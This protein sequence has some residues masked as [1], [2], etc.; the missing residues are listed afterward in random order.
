MDAALLA[1]SLKHANATEVSVS[2][3]SA[4]GAAATL[5]AFDLTRGDA[6]ATAQ[7]KLRLRQL[8]TF[9]SPRVGNEVRTPAPVHLL[10]ICVLHPPALVVCGCFLFGCQ[11]R[12]RVSS[13][14]S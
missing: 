1:A 3:H 12:K 13:R 2:G 9:G 6:H 5:H 14:L 7:G 8:V 11:S 10:E 4:G